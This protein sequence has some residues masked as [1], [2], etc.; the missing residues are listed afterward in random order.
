MDY[1]KMQSRDIIDPHVRELSPA[2]QE[3]VIND[4]R[5]HAHRIDVD[6]TQHLKLDWT[7]GCSY[8][9]KT[10]TSVDIQHSISGWR[11]RSTS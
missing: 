6:G 1:R 11:T 8:L 10:T 4:V 5:H 2:L 9:A 7:G 3:A